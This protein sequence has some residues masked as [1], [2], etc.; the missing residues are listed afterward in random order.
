MEG[1]KK[2]IIDT[3]RNF[4]KLGIPIEDVIKATGLSKVELTKL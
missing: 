2:G 4:L 3:A 1:E